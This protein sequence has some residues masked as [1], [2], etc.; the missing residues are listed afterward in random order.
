MRGRRGERG[1]ST[2]VEAAILLPGIMCLVA[3]VVFG[4]RLA[5]ANMALAAAVNQAARDASISRTS[6]EAKAALTE[7]LARGLAEHN[8]DCQDQEVSFDVAQV[9]HPVGETGSVSVSATCTVSVA[10]L[11]L[12]GVPGTVAVAATG[13]S[14][15]DSFRGR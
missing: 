1:L 9:T 2:A 5:L 11:L 7:S 14:P 8:L 6:A 15:I 3:L 4:A 10:D 12:P 13:V